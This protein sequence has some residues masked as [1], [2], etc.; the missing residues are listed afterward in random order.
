MNNPNN[1]FDRD[2]SSKFVNAYRENIKSDLIQITGDKL[3]NIL[4]KHLHKIGIRQS[5]TTPLSIFLTV[6]IAKLT[7]TFNKT[8]GI[9]APVWEA[10]FL[11]AMGISFIWLIISLIHIYSCRKESSLPDLMAIIKN[12]EE[13]KT[14]IAHSVNGSSEDSLIILTARYGTKNT[15]TDVVKILQDKVINNSLLIPVTN[16]TMG[17]DPVVG[18]GKTLELTYSFKGSEKSTTIQENGTLKLP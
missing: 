4:L 9:D 11:L 2:E 15:Y 5:W 17:G 1:L 12:I 16:K 14:R 6:F 8:L 7:T 10:L 3:E 18:A 13:G